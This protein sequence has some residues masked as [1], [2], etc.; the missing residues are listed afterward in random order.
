MRHYCFYTYILSNPGRTVFYIGFTKSLSKRLREHKGNRGT[1][2]SF[3]GS[4]YCYELVYF[5][6]HKYVLNAIALEKQLKRWRKSKKIALIK[7][8]NPR[9]LTLNGQFY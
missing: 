9:M 7:S 6:T 4:V 3:A 1:R 2:N 5:E 8:M